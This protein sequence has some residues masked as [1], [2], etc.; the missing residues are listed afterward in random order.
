MWVASAVGPQ[1]RC[2][3][4]AHVSGWAFA[5]VSDGWSDSFDMTPVA[6]MVE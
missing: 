5:C 1:F 3:E 2:P 4:V 6:I